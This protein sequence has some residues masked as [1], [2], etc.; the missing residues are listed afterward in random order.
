M[1]IDD[2]LTRADR[3]IIV[4]YALDS[5]KAKKSENRVP[6]MEYIHMYHGESILE[7][8]LKSGIINNIYSLHDSVVIDLITLFIFPTK[9]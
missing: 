6:G 5:I 7:A 2:I 4:K 1:T 9:I 3:Q 8:A